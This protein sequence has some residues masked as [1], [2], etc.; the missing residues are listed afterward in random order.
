MDL[1]V[2]F[3]KKLTFLAIALFQSRLRDCARG[4]QCFKCG[5]TISLCWSESQVIPLVGICSMYLIYCPKIFE[6]M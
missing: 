6:T 1:V 2:W 5:M 3:G 4:N